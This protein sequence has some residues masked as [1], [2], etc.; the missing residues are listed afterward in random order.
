MPETI[1]F[2]S[3]KKE[4]NNIISVLRAAVILI[5]IKMTMGGSKKYFLSA[6]KIHSKQILP[7]SHKY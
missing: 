5:F 2:I 1:Y 3:R 6:A 7:M 4:D